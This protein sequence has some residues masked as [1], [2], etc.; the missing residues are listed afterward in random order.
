MNEGIVATRAFIEEL[1][2]EGTM[3]SLHLGSVGSRR[4]VVGTVPDGVDLVAAGFRKLG[5]A[6]FKGLAPLVVY[7]VVDGGA[8]RP[9]EL[10]AAP[11]DSLLEA[12]DELY[13]V[14]MAAER[15]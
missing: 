2:L 9:E 13:D 8:W 5:T 3:Q 7:E 15:L 4:Y 11:F 14:G 1:D 6:E 12:T 10:E